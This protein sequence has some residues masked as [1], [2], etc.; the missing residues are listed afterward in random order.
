M[1]QPLVAVTFC[2]LLACSLAAP[3]AF[4]NTLSNDAVLQQPVTIWGTGTPGATVT[5]AVA[6]TADEGARNVAGGPPPLS[7][8]VGADGIWR[9]AIDAAEGRIHVC[10][11]N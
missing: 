11:H 5:T 7:A 2:G 6:V 3:F 8:E 10:V 1:Q 4:S 9:Q